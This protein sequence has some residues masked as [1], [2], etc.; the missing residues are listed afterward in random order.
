LST[1]RQLDPMSLIFN[2]LEAA[3]LLARGQ[4]EQAQ[5]R[6][7]RAFEIDPEFWV[8]HLSQAWFHLAEGQPEQALASARRAESLA[9]GSSQPTAFAGA[10][11]ARMGRVDEARAV[12]QGLLALGRQR[13][14]LP[15]VLI[16]AV[17]SATPW[18]FCL[19]C[20]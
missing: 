4:R 10:L 16:V 19:I 18:A 13:C 3:T 17:E 6:L 11:L 2:A 9:D 7:A 15:L 5:T 8:A 1:A 20:P 12:L 14:A